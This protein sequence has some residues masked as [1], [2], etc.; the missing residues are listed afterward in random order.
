MNRY[1]WSGIC[2]DE[3]LKGIEEIQQIVGRYA[4]IL[5]FQRFSDMALSLVL[6]LDEPDLPVLHR[7]L[8]DI[9]TINEVTL[10][11]VP[12]KSC[13]LF[14]NITFTKGTGDLLIEVPRVPG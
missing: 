1:F 10:E 2:H 13:I 9:L 5:N 8:S 12:G 3:R 7:E 4:S 6:E 14:L 11:T